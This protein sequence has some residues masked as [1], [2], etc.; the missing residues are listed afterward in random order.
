M[1]DWLSRVAEVAVL[2][3]AVTSMLSVGL[4]AT[5]AEIV[6]RLSNPGVLA[7]ILIPNFLVVPLVALGVLQLLPLDRPLR[8]ALLL[9]ATAAGAPI[10][11]KLIEVAEGRLERSAILL[12]AVLPVT[13]LYMPFV[14]PVLVPEATVNAAAIALPLVLTMLLPLAVGLL[15]HARRNEWARRLRPLLPPL[16]TVALLVFVAAT[17]W[18]GA[19]AIADLFGEGTPIL[20]AFVVIMCAFVTGYG[21]GGR[22]RQVR[23]VLGLGTAQ[24]NIA[25][26][27]V[28]ATESFHNPRVTVMVVVTSM[29]ALAV[30]FP[31][32]IVMRTLRRR[33]TTEHSRAAG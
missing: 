28:V 31:I 4:G 6:G 1:A 26:A 2:V 33:T 29:L 17:V 13:V 30:L 27:M 16:S 25:A 15:V 14:V 8:I 11:I 20:A 32:A 12:V 19:G 10:L 7:R 23:E 22:R 18:V 9:L 3:F 24:R 5:V 21:F